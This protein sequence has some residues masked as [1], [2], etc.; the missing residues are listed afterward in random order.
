MAEHF[1]EFKIGQWVEIQRRDLFVKVYS[2]GKLFG[3]L[4]SAKVQSIGARPDTRE[5]SP[6]L[7]IGANLMSSP[8][9]STAALEH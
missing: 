9:A 8:G 2:D 4:K 7:S 5:K 6:T 1:L 3:T